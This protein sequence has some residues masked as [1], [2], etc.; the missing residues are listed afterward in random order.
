MDGGLEVYEQALVE[1]MVK[2]GEVDPCSDIHVS[3]TPDSCR[4]KLEESCQRLSIA[5][6]ATAICQ[7]RCSALVEEVKELRV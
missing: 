1:D 5:H 7:I 3:K 2:A 6:Y 4:M